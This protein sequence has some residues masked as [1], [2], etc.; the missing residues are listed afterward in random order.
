[1]GKHGWIGSGD[2]PLTDFIHLLLGSSSNRNSIIADSSS[3]T[4][5]NAAASF[6]PGSSSN[7][8][9]NAAPDSPEATCARAIASFC[10]SGN[11]SANGEEVLHLPVIVDAAE[12]SP[13][14]AQA[15][16]HQI[17]TFLGKEYSKKP[18]IQYNAIMLVRILCDN[19]GASFTRNFD[20][21]FVSTVKDM[22]RHCKDGGTQQIV[23][24]TLDALEVNKQHDAGLQGLLAMWAKEKGSSAS[25][26]RGGPMYQQPQPLQGYPDARQ[27][28]SRG[29]PTAVEL[30]SRVEEARNT[31]KILLQLVQSTPSTEIL[32]NELMK[33]FSER[34][35]SASRSMQVYIACQN[36]APDHD[37]MQTLIE[38]NEQLSLA[39]SRYQRAVLAARR[40]MGIPASPPAM[41]EPIGHSVFAPP[42]SQQNMS[43]SQPGLAA[44]P[45]NGWQ[46]PAGPPPSHN[47]AQYQRE[48]QEQEQNPFAD[49][50][51]QQ[52]SNSAFPQP[53]QA[54]NIDS[55]AVQAKP[56]QQRDELENLYSSGTE[57]R[58][59][60]SQVSPV[61]NHSDAQTNAPAPVS[62]QS[63]PRPGL[64][65]Y[66]E[67]EIT[68]SYVGRQSSAANGLTMHGAGS[69]EQQQDPSGM[70]SRGRGY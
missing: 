47:T 1:M 42:P 16:C 3:T 53:T 67:S 60:V 56:Y 18:H 29:L 46:S 48:A 28:R 12:S 52:H 27:P 58:T 68:Q 6:V 38:T 66:H 54:F 11:T 49:P 55:G 7:N 13:Q 22:L 5:N 50:S 45:A 59:P 33:E 39:M 21:Q 63:P 65:P 40:E 43:I 25:L 69:G 34:C 24:E 36:P 62:P 51:E 31:A 35:Q 57:A 15:A 2:C 44:A 19:P 14:A 64:G 8:F 23:R 26:S 20:K 70:A 32:N 30:A 4:N 10:E 17:R 37:T 9:A 61:F 41:Q